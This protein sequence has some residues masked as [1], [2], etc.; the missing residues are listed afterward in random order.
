[1]LGISGNVDFA[2][3]DKRG[4]RADNVNRL[5]EVV[6]VFHVNIVLVKDNL[7]ADL[8]VR[9]FFSRRAVRTD[10]ETVGRNEII[11][12][13]AENIFDDAALN[14]Q[15]NAEIIRARRNALPRVIDDDAVRIAFAVYAVDDNFRAVELQ[16]AAISLPRKNRG[17]V[18]AYAHCRTNVISRARR[19]AVNF[20]VAVNHAARA[21]VACINRR[22]CVGRIHLQDGRT[23]GNSAACQNRAQLIFF[24]VGNYRERHNAI[25]IVH[26]KFQALDFVLRRLERLRRSDGF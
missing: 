17:A 25:L 3:L 18:G 9:E 8:N 15:F 13:I 11:A 2:L 24:V 4:A 16:D 19:H 12:V 10:Y 7:V 26:Q 22:D 1:M 5:V 20:R 14:D 21:E 6:A 23:S